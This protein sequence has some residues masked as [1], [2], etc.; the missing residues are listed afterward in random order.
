MLLEFEFCTYNTPAR[1][2]VIKLSDESKALTIGNKE[3][4]CMKVELLAVSAATA[5][6]IVNIMKID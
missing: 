6:T 5:A 1:E 3:S 2:S 4:D